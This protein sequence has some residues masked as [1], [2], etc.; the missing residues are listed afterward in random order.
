MGVLPGRN[1][2][3]Y[4][5]SESRKPFMKC[6]FCGGNK[7]RV[8]DTE[9]EED[10][11]VHRR[12]MCVQCGKRFN[13][14]ER[15]LLNYPMIIKKDLTRQDYNREKLMR[16]IRIACAKSPVS[17]EKIEGIV[18]EIERELQMQGKNEISSRTIGDMVIARL[19]T[20]DQI[21]YVRFAIVYLQLDDLLSLRNEID[22]LLSENKM[23]EL[24]E[25]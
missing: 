2:R 24:N 18:E 16:G 12:R 11:R 6:P 23:E 1:T 3:F 19:K 17:N 10:T 4:L 9:K 5:N 7:T 15:P 22:R 13:T 20:I 8:I 14:D 25:V 21:A